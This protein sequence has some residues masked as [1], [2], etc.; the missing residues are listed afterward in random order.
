MEDLLAVDEV[1][2]VQQLLHH[3]L[4][5]AEVELDIGVAEQAS[6]VVL[7]KVKDQVEGRLVP[8]V[9]ARLSFQI[10]MFSLDIFKFSNKDLCSAN[11]DE[12]DNVLMSE[13]LQNSDL[14]KII[15][16]KKH[17]SIIVSLTRTKI[18]GG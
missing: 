12:I 7:G 5:L 15:A 2:P 8:I 6:Q 1:E 17:F 4:D 18:L 9:L 10:N 3:L 14:P 16:L 13:Q 11:L